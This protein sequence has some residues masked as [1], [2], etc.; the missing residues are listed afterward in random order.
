[1][2]TPHAW[3]ATIGV[4]GGATVAMSLLAARGSRVHRAALYGAAS[5]VSGALAATF[6]KTSVETL[7]LDGAVSVVSRWPTY[8]LAVSGVASA[9]LFQAALHVG[10][11][12][13]SQPVMLVLNPI[14]S[15]WISVWLFAEHFTHDK[16][17]L[18]AG[19][20]GFAALIVGVVLLTRTAPQQDRVQTR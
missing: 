10:P 19:A 8:G 4:F 15:I 16:A 7:S 9:I 12:T 14:V 17:V 1:M 2:P 6:I 18:A 20:A 3:L 13:V 11:L 5:A